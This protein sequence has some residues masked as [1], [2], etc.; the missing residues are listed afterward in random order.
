[1]R[2]AVAGATGRLGRHLVEVLAARG[3]TV[4]AMSRSTGVDL[5]TGTGLAEALRG[6]ECVIDT[7]SGPSPE[8]Q[9]ATDFFRTAS[10]NLQS[11]SARAG[12]QRILTVSIIG[13]DRFSAGYMAAKQVHEETMRSGPVPVSILRAAQFHEFVGQLVD[14][15]RQAE[16]SYVPRMRTQLVAALTV[17]EALAALAADANPSGA[18]S[19]GETILEV[20]GPREEQMVD[21]ARRLAAKRGDAVRIEAVSSTDDPDG[22]LYESGGLLPGPHA[23]LAGPTFDEWLEHTF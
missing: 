1:M 23:M 4:K 3:H 14:W 8:Q 13:L 17:A 9:P 21:A 2:I 18:D 7:A 10:R 20:A 22:P 16:L 15:G 11:A 5:I 19:A 12:V 6:A